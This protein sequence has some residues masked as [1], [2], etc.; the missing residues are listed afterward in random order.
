[1]IE[2]HRNV[3]IKNP[4]TTNYILCDTTSNGGNQV[5]NDVDELLNK[6]DRY[7]ESLALPHHTGWT[8]GFNIDFGKKKSRPSQPLIEMYSWHGSSEYYNNSLKIHNSNL[9][10]RPPG[11]GAYVQEALADGYKFGFTGDS[12][13]HL[14]RPASNNGGTINHNGK[15]GGYYA[16][17]GITAAY[18]K[19]LT[20]DAIWDA[21]IKRR[22]YAT[23]GARILGFFTI[24]G[25]FV[26]EEFQTSQ[27]PTIRVKLYGTD[28]FSEVFVFKNGDQLVYYGTPNK[29]KVDFTFTDTNVTTGN[30]YS[31]YVK[32]I[33][34]DGHR[35][36]ISPIWVNLKA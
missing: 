14:G 13:N 34:E 25:H 33:Q 31:Y 23:T 18:A 16:R 15:S 20:R 6:L 4:E 9:A 22:T 19:N 28:K 26:G 3:V 8:N 29:T 30:I 12:D 1:M 32:G 24:N 10:Q 11:T 7:G 21:L 2:G 27:D 5:V 17:M 36:W 35:I